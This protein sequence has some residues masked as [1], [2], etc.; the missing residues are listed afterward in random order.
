[1]FLHEKL[2]QIAKQAN[3]DDKQNIIDSLKNMANECFLYTQKE[4]QF[5]KEIDKTIHNYRII[6]KKAD[7]HW[8]LAV[9]NL[10]KDGIFLADVEGFR[11]LVK[12]MPEFA[13][14]FNED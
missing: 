1:M 10:E 12:S 7:N 5:L 13:T 2:F 14:I 6:F 3:L 4:T 11:N 9:K 8:K